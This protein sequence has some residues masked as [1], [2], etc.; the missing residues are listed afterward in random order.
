[1]KAQLSASSKGGIYH[2][3][4][5]H[6]NSFDKDKTTSNDTYVKSETQEADP[7]KEE[8]QNVYG[9][10]FIVSNKIKNV[11]EYQKVIESKNYHQYK[12][13]LMK[14]KIK[15]MDK[16]LSQLKPIVCLNSIRSIYK[17]Q[18]ETNE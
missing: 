1:M 12:I 2:A 17:K 8:P 9:K 13:L 15:V 4:A 5:E 18:S 7:S 11:E 6:M 14:N 10:L 3:T 16:Y